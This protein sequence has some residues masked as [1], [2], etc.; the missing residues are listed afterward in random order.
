MHAEL[1][2][3]IPF[4]S[5]RGPQ[6]QHPHVRPAS[7]GLASLV[8]TLQPKFDPRLRSGSAGVDINVAARCLWGSFV[9]HEH[10]V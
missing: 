7:V 10:R 8:S 9:V 2:M 5:Y 3:Q 1:K 4:R 6:H